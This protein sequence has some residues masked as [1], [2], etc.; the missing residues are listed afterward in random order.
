MPVLKRSY[1]LD[2]KAAEYVQGRAKKLKQ[3]ASS[4]LSEI[5]LDAARQDARDRVLSEFG[6][7]IEVPVADLRRWRKLLGPK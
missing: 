7:G 3:S 4:V 5:V 1:S 6:E 2:E